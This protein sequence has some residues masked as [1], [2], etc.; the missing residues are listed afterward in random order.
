VIPHDPLSTAVAVFVG[1]AAHEA[2]HAP[3]VDRPCYRFEAMW[4]SG[5]N[6]V[7]LSEND[8]NSVPL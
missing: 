8:L 3:A 4:R 7:S 1:E 2:V 5:E 6:R